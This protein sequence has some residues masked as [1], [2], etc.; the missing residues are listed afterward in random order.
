[1]TALRLEA[2]FPLYITI[3][4]FHP[5]IIFTLLINKLKPVSC[6]KYGQSYIN[7]ESFSAYQIT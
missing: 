6:V 7:L 4:C 5:R 2:H 1:M 3:F